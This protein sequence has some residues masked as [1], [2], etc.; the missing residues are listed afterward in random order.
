MSMLRQMIIILCAILTITLPFAK[1]NKVAAPHP[2]EWFIY[3]CI[4]YSL[5]KMKEKGDFYIFDIEITLMNIF[6]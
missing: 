4:I 5:Q 3:S 1:F 6:V 2:V